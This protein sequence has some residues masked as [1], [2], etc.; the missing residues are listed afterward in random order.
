MFP[1]S[2]QLD[3]NLLVRQKGGNQDVTS[4]FLAHMAQLSAPRFLL[5]DKRQLIDSVLD[6][7]CE[8]HLKVGIVNAF[9]IRHNIA[10]FQLDLV[11]FPSFEEV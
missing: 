10:F 7:D 5:D 2:S 8:E 6:F 3:K 4:T 9:R 1:V 11:L